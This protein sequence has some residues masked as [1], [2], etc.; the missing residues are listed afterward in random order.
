MGQFAA[1]NALAHNVYL[2]RFAA[3]TALPTTSRHVMP[4]A[5]TLFCLI[6]ARKSLDTVAARATV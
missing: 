3:Q 2:A 4:A 6:A 1:M 5:Q